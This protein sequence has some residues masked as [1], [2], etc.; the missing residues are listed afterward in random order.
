MQ[1]LARELDLSDAMICNW[2]RSD[3]ID[4]GARPGLSSPQAAE[5]ATVRRRVRELEE[6]VFILN[7][8]AEK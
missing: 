8:A 2:R 7:R 1:Q 5:L 4:S 6:E 3:E